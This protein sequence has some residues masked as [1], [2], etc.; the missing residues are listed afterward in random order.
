MTPTPT[1]TSLPSLKPNSASK[2]IA[3]EREKRSKPCARECVKALVVYRLLFNYIYTGATPHAKFGKHKKSKEGAIESDQ[4]CAICTRATHSIIDYRFETQLLRT[5]SNSTKNNRTGDQKI[6]ERR[7][8]EEPQNRK[9]KLNISFAAYANIHVYYCIFLNIH[10][11]R[12]YVYKQCSLV[13]RVCLQN[14]LE[15]QAKQKQ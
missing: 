3:K 14:I 13:F 15:C 5:N 6:N 4:S 11:I 12:I 2:E 1:P 8:E 10:V 9:E 7:K